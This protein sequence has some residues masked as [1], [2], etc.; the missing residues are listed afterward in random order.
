MH[1][2]AFSATSYVYVIC[3]AVL[4]PVLDI[5]KSCHPPRKVQTAYHSFLAS[6]C[7]NYGSLQVTACSTGLAN[8]IASERLLEVPV[9]H[10]GLRYEFYQNLL[11]LPATNKIILLSF[12]F[13]VPYVYMLFLNLR[14]EE[15]R[16]IRQEYPIA[17]SNPT[18]MITNY[19]QGNTFLFLTQEIITNIIITKG[20][21]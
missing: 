17:S 21:K 12:Q 7:G 9:M 2:L 4:P 20:I 8:L 10:F 18:F 6:L 14:S 5:S 15:T 11:Q 1:S 19:L 3:L 16:V 13:F